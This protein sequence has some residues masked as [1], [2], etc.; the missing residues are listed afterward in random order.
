MSRMDFVDVVLDRSATGE[1][2]VAEV[3][4]IAL[5]AIHSFRLRP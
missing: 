4:K 3:T 2:L 1:E 5:V